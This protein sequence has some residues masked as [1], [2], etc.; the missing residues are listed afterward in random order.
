MSHRQ[1]VDYDRIKYSSTKSAISQDI[2]SITQQK[3]TPQNVLYRFTNIFF[4]NEKKMAVS[5]MLSLWA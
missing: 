1:S 4:V 2:E 5:P 3:R